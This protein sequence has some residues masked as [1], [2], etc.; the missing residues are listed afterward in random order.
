MRRKGNSDKAKN[1]QGNCNFPSPPGQHSLTAYR[2]V[3]ENKTI[4]HTE[5]FVL[6]QCQRFHIAENQ[7]LRRCPLFLLIFCHGFFPSATAF[8]FMPAGAVI[9]R[10]SPNVNRNSRLVRVRN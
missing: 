6:G 8:W 2:S 10:A 9:T 1:A 7:K 4:A 5:V 3:V